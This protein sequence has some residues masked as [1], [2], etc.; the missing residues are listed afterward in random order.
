MKKITTPA[1]G[2]V[3]L[4]LVLAFSNAFGH[5]E[6]QGSAGTK[7]AAAA[8]DSA[9]GL[10]EVKL[11]E[12][13]IEMPASVSAGATTFTV[14][15]T[16]KET[17][18]FEVEGNGIEKALKPRLKKGES[19]SLQVDLKPGTY[20]VYCPVLGHKGRGMSLDLTVK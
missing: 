19:G 3:S 14:T 20:K 10:V 4:G 12:Y 8:P 6:S 18:G 5:G 17:H 2:I 13:K 7:T 15:N 11:T 1:A 16:G 9:K